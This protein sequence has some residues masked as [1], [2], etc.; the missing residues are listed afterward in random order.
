MII[1]YTVLG[2]IAGASLIYLALVLFSLKHG[3]TQEPACRYCQGLAHP[4]DT[5]IESETGRGC[6]QTGGGG[7]D[8]TP[9]PTHTTGD[10]RFWIDGI[11][12]RTSELNADSY[13]SEGVFLPSFKAGTPG[14]WY[15]VDN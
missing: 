14:S 12:K 11:V 13:K 1:L 5:G 7:N 4:C 15:T 2:I 10:S 8:G 3:L 6:C 9:V